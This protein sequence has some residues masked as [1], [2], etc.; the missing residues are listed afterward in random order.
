MMSF[1]NRRDIAREI[2]IDG[3]TRVGR[4]QRDAFF[5]GS[6][7]WY[8]WAHDSDWNRIVFDD[9]GISGTRPRN[10]FGGIADHLRFLN[11]N[12]GHIVDDTPIAAYSGPEVTRA[13]TSY[14]CASVISAL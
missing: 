12:S 5:D 1:D 4:Q 2:L 14:S 8:R 6:P 7:H 13:T 10:K 11:V 3:G 9:N